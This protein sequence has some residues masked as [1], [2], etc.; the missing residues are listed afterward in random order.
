MP[1]RMSLPGAHGRRYSLLDSVAKDVPASFWKDGRTA[2]PAA[3]VPT[4]G[5]ALPAVV[6]FAHADSRSAARHMTVLY[7]GCLDASVRTLGVAV[8]V[9]AV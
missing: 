7:T 8:N 3:V 4:V 2:L 6:P 9:P 5:H 1:P